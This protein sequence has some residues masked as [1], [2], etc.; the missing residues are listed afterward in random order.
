MDII[1]EILWN[2]QSQRVNFNLTKKYNEDNRL[3]STSFVGLFS[4]KFYVLI[5]SSLCSFVC[6]IVFGISFVKV[7]GN[8]SMTYILVCKLVFILSSKKLHYLLYQ[9]ILQF[10][11]H[12]I[13]ILLLLKL[14]ILFN[15]LFT[16]SLFLF[17][18]S[19]SFFLFK[20]HHK[21]TDTTTTT[22][23]SPPPLHYTHLTPPPPPLATH[24][25]PQ[26][27]INAKKEKEKKNLK[28]I[29]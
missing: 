17:I 27:T 6:I 20:N 8:A 19:P 28:W 23:T 26:S 24:K 29:D 13:S 9:L 21:S 4:D 5:L 10:Y 14:N 12:P 11:L 3:L 1:I 18:L 25:N 16:I 15:Y 7:V 2:P 22:T